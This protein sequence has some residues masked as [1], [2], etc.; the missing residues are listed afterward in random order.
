MS[1]HNKSLYKAQAELDNIWEQLYEAH[2]VLNDHLIAFFAS[3]DHEVLYKQGYITAI[4]DTNEKYQLVLTRSTFDNMLNN[5]FQSQSIQSYKPGFET[6]G[7]EDLY[8]AEMKAA[9]EAAQK[10]Q[11]REAKREARSAIKKWIEPPD[12][13][14]GDQINLEHQF[15]D[16]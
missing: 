14:I 7:W 16:L 6:L 13:K 10:K 8:P 15:I 9:R 5:V 12:L 2:V 3:P 11:D 1:S 4:A